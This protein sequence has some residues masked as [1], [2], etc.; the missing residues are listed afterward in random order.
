MSKKNKKEKKEFIS[1]EQAIKMLPDGESIHTFRAAGPCRL[2]ANI[3][4]NSLIKD[5]EKYSDKL[6]ISGKNAQEL[7]HGIVFF[8]DIGPLFVETKKRK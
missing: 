8:D 3:D 4:K 2:G 6:E 1:F 7:N 5:M